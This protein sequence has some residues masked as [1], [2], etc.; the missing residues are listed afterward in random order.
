MFKAPAVSACFVICMVTPSEVFSTRAP[1][2]AMKPIIV[3]SPEVEPQGEFTHQELSKKFV[4][5]GKVLQD[6][7]ACGI[8][9][10][11]RAG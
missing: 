10:A 4:G 3:S 1:A 8:L 5:Q 6:F 9:A 2:T 7:E 11:Y